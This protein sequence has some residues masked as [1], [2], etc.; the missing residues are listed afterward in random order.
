M[1][2]NVSTYCLLR[3]IRALSCHLTQLRRYSYTS[4]FI[5]FLKFSVTFFVCLFVCLF[6]FCFLL[7]R[8]WGMTG[9][10]AAAE[11]MT[12]VVYFSLNTG[13]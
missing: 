8:E 1:V 9:L 2:V 13:S 12:F 11:E 3:M 4:A 5:L 10:V 6:V 7:S